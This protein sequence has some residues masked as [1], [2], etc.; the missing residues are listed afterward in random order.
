M[1]IKIKILVAAKRR[2]GS[3]KSSNFQP[4]FAIQPDRC[5]F[6]M[7]DAY[8]FLNEKLSSEKGEKIFFCKL[9]IKYDNVFYTDIYP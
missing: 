6:N 9:D 4:A 3:L 5:S 1:K 7:Q 2:W 8:E